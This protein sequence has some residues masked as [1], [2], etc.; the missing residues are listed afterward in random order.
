MVKLSKKLANQ[1]LRRLRVRAKVSGT[2]VRPRLTVKISNRHIIAQ[3]INDEAQKTLI[4]ATTVGSDKVGTMAEKAAQ[5]GAEIARKAIK[6]KIKAV[7]F[8]RNRRVYSVRLNAFA[9]AAR[10]EGLE[11]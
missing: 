4:S 2:A 1:K 9:E 10:Q 6:A 5:M 7:V 8:D 11:F 3:I